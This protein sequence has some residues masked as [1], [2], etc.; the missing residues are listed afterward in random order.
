MSARYMALTRDDKYVTAREI[1]NSYN[2]SY[3][4]VA[5]VLQILAK[6]KIIQ[7]FQGVNGG[8]TLTRN[9]DEISLADIIKA[10]EPKY[11]ITDCL[12]N[13]F[14]EESCSYFNCCKIKNPLAGIQKKID[15]IFYET[16]LTELI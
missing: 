1:A 12:R 3:E 6:R 16:K 15:K 5:K 11:E 9:S 7:S 8:Y 4:L 10:I 13:G 2:L 14:D